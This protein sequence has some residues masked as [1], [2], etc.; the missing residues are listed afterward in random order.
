MK[1]KISNEKIMSFYTKYI[2]TNK[3]SPTFDYACEKLGIKSKSTLYNKLNYLVK[4][5]YMTKLQNGAY[6]PECL[7]IERK[8]WSGEYLCTHIDE[9]FDS[10]DRALD[11][12]LDR[13]YRVRNGK[14]KSDYG[15]NTIKNITGEKRIKAYGFVFTRIGNKYIKEK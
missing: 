2:L 7:K 9:T 10:D 3:I 15:Y 13:V 4:E 6:F 5:G 12:T 8:N 1:N 14:L 11:F